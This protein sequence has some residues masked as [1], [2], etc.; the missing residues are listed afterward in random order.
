MTTLEDLRQRVRQQI[1]GYSRDQQQIAM[2]TA[3]MTSSAA[4]FTLDTSTMTAIS[5][6]L[7]EIDD[8]LILV[9]SLDVGSGTV[10]VMGNALGRGREGSTAAAHTAGALVTMSPL[11]P[12]QGITDAINATIQDMYPD[13]PVTKAT[14]IPKLAP[15]YEYGLPAEAVGVHYITMQTIGPSKIWY[16]GPRWRYN[17][18]ADPTDFPTGRSVQLLDDVVPGRAMRIVYL[19]PPTP[20]SLAT[21]VFETVTGYPGS[22]IDCVIWGAMSRLLPS[23]ETARLQAQSIEGTERDNLVPAKA[24]LQTAA[25]YN[26]LAQD[27]L[28]HE[29]ARFFDET[30]NFAF[31]QGG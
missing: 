19:V 29:R 16:P 21:D 30:P 7:V 24:A 6:G 4:S 3:D 25:Y 18:M 12:R 13:L 15:V 26:Q 23:Y 11:M 28:A 9:K 31:W 27:A 10:S 2:L 22:A 5:R 8:E 17:S 1:L 20:L 14:E